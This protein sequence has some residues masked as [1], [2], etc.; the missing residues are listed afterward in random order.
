MTGGFIKIAPSIGSECGADLARLNPLKANIGAGKAG[1]HPC[2]ISKAIP[3]RRGEREMENARLLHVDTIIWNCYAPCGSIPS[4]FTDASERVPS[5]FVNPCLTSRFFHA[6]SFDSRFLYAIN[7]RNR[8]ISRSFCRS[9]YARYAFRST[10]NYVG[11]LNWKNGRMK[12]VFDCLF[13]MQRAVL[14]LCWLPLLNHCHAVN[15]GNGRKLFFF[16]F[17]LGLLCYYEHYS[18]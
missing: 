7:R 13:Q 4:F 14:L 10:G 12:N 15:P 9:F 18:F 2:D 6:K 11:T 16:F 17:C 5:V 8:W 3:G 1:I